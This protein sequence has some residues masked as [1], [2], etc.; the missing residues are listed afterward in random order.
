MNYINFILY[1]LFILFVGNIFLFSS[2]LISKRNIKHNKL[3]KFIKFIVFPF[4][5][6]S[7]ITASL[8]LMLI[9]IITIIPLLIN[10]TNS[11]NSKLVLTTNAE[12]TG[13]VTINNET[14]LKF[15]LYKH[16][17][18]PENTSPQELYKEMGSTSADPS[19]RLTLDTQIYTRLSDKKEFKIK[20]YCTNC[21]SIPY[22]N[23][24]ILLSKKDISV[25]DLNLSKAN[26]ILATKPINA[27]SDL[28]AMTYDLKEDANYIYIFL[29]DNAKDI[30]IYN[31]YLLTITKKDKVLNYTK[32]DFG[33]KIEPKAFTIKDNLLT[34]INKTPTGLE[35]LSIEFDERFTQKKLYTEY[36][37]Y[38]WQ[39]NW[40][41]TELTVEFDNFNNKL[42]IFYYNRSMDPSRNHLSQYP[43]YEVF[44][45]N[46]QTLDEYNKAVADYNLRINKLPKSTV[47]EFLLETNKG[48]Y[49]EYKPVYFNAFG[50]FYIEKYFRDPAKYDD[51]DGYVSP[52]D[53]R[54][55]CTTE[56]Y[57]RVTR[58]YS[59]GLLPND[60]DNPIIKYFN[61]T[62]GGLSNMIFF[63]LSP[64][65]TNGYVQ[66]IN[67]ASINTS[68]RFIPEYA[69]G[70]IVNE[71]G[72]PVYY[73]YLN[74][75][76]TSTFAP[77][78]QHEIYRLPL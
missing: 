32:L 14:Y 74:P 26:P 2:K 73:Y 46:Y 63:R 36:I 49:A 68:I 33:K 37:P 60:T 64:E 78:E 62:V 67:D 66:D 6:V 39:F 21:I 10:L 3:Y 16:D 28:Q 17:P 48:F 69:E 24:I 45:I 51:R 31:Y 59:S 22:S 70:S 27:I 71:N 38:T 55:D 7:L 5:T 25:L 65:K 57:L 13:A 53:R 52:Y 15:D 12:L 34:V 72:K 54:I 75:K 19:G 50:E 44:N 40:Y 61:T 29:R 9:A 47:D 1:L 20:D 58:R 35:S 4:S 77:E 56:C 18:L 76:F 43:Y 11:I 41:S 23:G 8:N 42:H 30:A